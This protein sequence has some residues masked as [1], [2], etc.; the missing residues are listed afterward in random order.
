MKVIVPLVLENQTAISS[1]LEE[2]GQE[3]GVNNSSFRL[4]T[5]IAPGDIRGAI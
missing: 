3:T 4:I 2:E 5:Y 1:T